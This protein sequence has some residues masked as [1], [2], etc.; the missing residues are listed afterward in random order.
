MCPGPGLTLFPAPVRRGLCSLAP[1]SP[2]P[3]AEQRLGRPRA[4]APT[5]QPGPGG[6]VMQWERT[7]PVSL[8]DLGSV[9]NLQCDPGQ[10][11]SCLPVP[12]VS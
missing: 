10:L 7:Q 5:G 6:E 3:L 12:T 4:A 9:A 2:S 1:V 8:T 11:T